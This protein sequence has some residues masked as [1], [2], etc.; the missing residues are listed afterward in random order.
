[1]QS[2][3]GWLCSGNL[4]C[5]VSNWL[6]HF[7]TTLLLHNTLDQT[8]IIF[9]YRHKHVCIYVFITKVPRNLGL[10]YVGEVRFCPK[11]LGDQG[12]NEGEWVE[13]IERQRWIR[14]QLYRY[15]QCNE[16]QSLHAAALILSRDVSMCMWFGWLLGWSPQVAYHTENKHS[17]LQCTLWKSHW[18][19]GTVT[20]KLAITESFL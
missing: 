10:K 14:Q 16:E 20:I 11:K 15:D 1:M 19:P 3:G 8:F 12:K 2:T 7:C 5:Q 18:Q 17:W 6:G 4:L 9:I 13:A